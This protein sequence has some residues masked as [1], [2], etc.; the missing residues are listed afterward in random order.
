MPA[1]EGERK[2]NAN[3]RAGART[4]SHELAY[5]LLELKLS[6]SDNQKKTTG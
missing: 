5:M 4:R 1:E 2:N 6:K 3:G